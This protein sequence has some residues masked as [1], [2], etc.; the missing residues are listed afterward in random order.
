MKAFDRHLNL[1]LEDVCETW[2]EKNKQD[3]KPIPKKRFF[4]KLFLRGDSIVLIVPRV[5]P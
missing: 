1:I 2:T 5:Q 4:S 3:K